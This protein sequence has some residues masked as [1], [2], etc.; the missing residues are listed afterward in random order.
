VNSIENQLVGFC[1]HATELTVRQ[2]LSA[3]PAAPRAPVSH[4]ARH[5]YPA[6]S[7]SQYAR[8]VAMLAAAD[9]PG[10][11]QAE[12]AGPRRWRREV[13][14]TSPA[15]VPAAAA[16]VPADAG[17]GTV[18]ACTVGAPPPPVSLPT[19]PSAAPSCFFSLLPE[20]FFFFDL[21]FGE[22]GAATCPWPELA[23]AFSGEYPA[24]REPFAVPR[25]TVKANPSATSPPTDRHCVMCGCMA[26]NA[27]GPAPSD[28]RPCLCPCSNPRPT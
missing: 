5:V 17:A 25:E 21:C 24:P 8:N 19:A 11:K 3:H 22:S 23:V 9:R 7:L 18:G 20:L 26:S 12:T 13:K 16:S 28:S 4:S 2:S 15:A 14:L 6:S 27:A 10:A 1:T